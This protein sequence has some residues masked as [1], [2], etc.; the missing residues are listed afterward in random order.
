MWCFPLL[1]VVEP[2]VMTGV[3]TRAET[4]SEAG[5]TQERHAWSAQAPV[6]RNG[7][8]RIARNTSDAM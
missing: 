2:R 1:V 6:A 3:T 8:F 7:N 4:C 5:D